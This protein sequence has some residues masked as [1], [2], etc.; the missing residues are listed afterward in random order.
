MK[1][2]LRNKRFKITILLIIGILFANLLI[3]NGSTF[4]VLSKYIAYRATEKKGSN[5]FFS[6]ENRDFILYIDFC[7]NSLN[8][9]ATHS[10]NRINGSRRRITF[11]LGFQEEVNINEI[12]VNKVKHDNYKLHT[13]VIPMFNYRVNYL[14]I[15]RLNRSKDEFEIT[16]DYDIKMSNGRRDFYTLL[17]NYIEN[18]QFHLYNLW[19]P[20]L[21]NKLTLSDVF[22]GLIPQV[23]KTPLEMTVNLSNDGIVAGEGEITK[24]SENSYHVRNFDNELNDIFICGGDLGIIRETFGDIDINLYFRNSQQ[25]FFTGT[26]ETLFA[27]MQDIIN[28][29]ENFELR[30][31]NIYCI[32]I[33]AGGYGLMQSI[34][35]NEDYFKVSPDMKNYNKYTLI[36][37]EFIHHWWGNRIKSTGSG[38]F[39]LTEGLTVLYEWLTAK[40]ILGE[41]YFNDNIENAV[42][43][44][45]EIRGFENSIADANRVPPF[46]NIIIYRKAPLVLYQLMN[47]VGE[48]EFTEYCRLFLK[49]PGTYE[50]DAFINGLEN[51]AEMD[52]CQ[53]NEYWVNSTEIPSQKNDHYYVLIDERSEQEQQLD[54]QISVFYRDYDQDVLYEYLTSIES[55]LCFWNKYYYFL[56]WCYYRNEKFEKAAKA[57]NKTDINKDIKYYWESAYFKAKLEIK[58]GNKYKAFKYVED[59]LD[60]SYPIIRLRSMYRLYDE[61]EL[62]ARICN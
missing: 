42:A 45:L 19:Y 24:L 4:R 20:V 59:C 60:H 31:F 53:Y 16:I 35:I 15:N 29:F 30:S 61:L 57:F 49:T 55:E 56:G 54:H 27:G 9:T 23:K 5:K 51:Y 47:K 1:T 14:V 62:T 17:E 18:D 22:S 3:I 11:W 32:P 12:K 8:N 40:D 28:T 37:H 26:S 10:I 50:W 36:W 34:M 39:M 21:G 33:V 43:E 25:H 46:G 48:D 6:I 2:N 7:E 44:V 13:L 52:L 58:N 41:E 38:R